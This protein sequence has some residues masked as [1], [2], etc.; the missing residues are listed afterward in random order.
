MDLK[1]KVFKLADWLLYWAIIAIPFVASFSSAAVQSF[2][3][4]AVSSFLIK[5]FI[6]RERWFNSRFLAVPFILLVLF[7]LL[8]IFNSVSMRAS[9]QG[10]TKLVK[11]GLVLFIIAG[12]I[13]DR[14]HFKRVI[15]AILAGL[16]LSSLDGIYQFIFGVDFFRHKPYDTIIGLI[17]LKAAFPHTNIFAGY[18]A[19]F[20]PVAVPLFFYGAKGKKKIALG[21]VLSL[22][23]FCLIYTF[24]RSAAF[25]FWFVLLAM[26]LIK[27]DRAFTAIMVL[28]MLITP[29]LAPKNIKDWSKTVSSF[30]KLLLNKERLVLNETSFN[31]IRRHPLIGV[32]VNTYVLNYQQYKLHDTSEDTAD[33]GWYAHN[34]YLQM[35]SEI[36]I[37]GLFSFLWLM[38]LLLVKWVKFYRLNKDDLFGLCSLGI[39][40]GLIAFLINGLTETNLYYPKIAILF[41]YQAGLLSCILRLGKARGEH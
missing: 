24:S 32:G 12:E 19:L 21:A 34:S 9:I 13:K 36:G 17:R 37:F 11:Y 2:V 30:S 22:A 3:G 20:V 8:S 1:S 26:G 18:L 25:G 5:K 10:I 28:L 23:V 4:V 29:F 7:S 41:W 14:R 35:A 33:T 40:M 15:I 27:R 31:M 39:L 38:I 6:S 16:V